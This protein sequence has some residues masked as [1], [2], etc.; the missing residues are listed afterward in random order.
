MFQGK[1]SDMNIALDSANSNVTR[2][3][4]IQ[5]TTFLRERNEE[6]QTRL[7]KAFNE[8]QEKE[9]V[10]AKLEKEIEVER[11]K[12]K[13]VIDSMSEGDQAKYNQLDQLA[14]NLN[15]QNSK[16]HE[17][18]NILNNQKT[19]LETIAKSSNE[20]HEAVRLLLKLNEL[21]MKLI[22][23]KNDEQNRLTPAQ[24]REK[25]I[26][27]VRENKQALT[28]M[29]HQIKL[30]EHTLSEKREL[31]QQIDDDL[32]EGSSERHAK[33]KELKHRDEMMTEFMDKFKVNLEAETQ[34]I[35]IIFLILREM[36]FSSLKMLL[37]F[38]L[39][40]KKS[41]WSKTKLHRPLN[42]LL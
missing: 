41:N 3:Q 23:A 36:I 10:N 16:M 12:I 20:R 9:A 7:E 21:E 40:S 14:Q 1:L 32:D 6:I 22:A 25:L 17:Q 30:A 39:L 11:S 28:S 8:R 33:Y 18:I 38:N 2:Q 27:E 15:D 26:A 5:E 37:I 19:N 35:H 34:S 31:L 4:M 13:K 29:Q 24:E 42:K